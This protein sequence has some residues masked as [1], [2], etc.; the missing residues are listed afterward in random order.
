MQPQKDIPNFD[1][2]DISGFLRVTSVRQVLLSIVGSSLVNDSHR[3]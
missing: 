3:T 2:F 1:N